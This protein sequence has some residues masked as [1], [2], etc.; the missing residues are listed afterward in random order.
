[1]KYLNKTFSVGPALRQAPEP[2]CPLCERDEPQ[3]DAHVRVWKLCK[4][5]RTGEE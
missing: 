2:P 4:L 3:A 5:H 1:M